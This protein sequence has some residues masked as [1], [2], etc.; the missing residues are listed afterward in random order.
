[1]DLVNQARIHGVWQVEDVDP[2]SSP[3]VTPV[4]VGLMVAAGD[5]GEVGISERGQKIQRAG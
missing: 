3:E 5:G 4:W 1:L 2:A